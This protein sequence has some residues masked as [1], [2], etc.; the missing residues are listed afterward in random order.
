MRAD[1]TSISVQQ[2]AQETYLARLEVP[3]NKI[4]ALPKWRLRLVEEYVT[5][6]FDR[7]IS[8]FDLAE[9]AGLSRMYFA[10]QFRAATG[11]RP[12]E[13]LLHQRIE[14]AKTLLSNT[15]TPVAEVALAVGF[16][17]QAH[18]STV[19]KRITSET[20]ARWRCTRKNELLCIET[21]SQR[22]AI[23]RQSLEFCR[24]SD[25]P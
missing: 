16:C 14:H 5:G 13:Y 22:S 20:P 23:G 10:A 8:L 15:E 2:E 25:A 11:Y 9:V 19:F 17:S 12:H 6:N 21:P 1:R 18:F 4:R 24:A 3:R 7:C